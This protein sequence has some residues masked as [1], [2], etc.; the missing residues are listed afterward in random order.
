M[1]VVKRLRIVVQVDILSPL[2]NDEKAALA[3]CLTVASFRS[4][5]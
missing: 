5:I 3:K 4:T 2:K 1:V